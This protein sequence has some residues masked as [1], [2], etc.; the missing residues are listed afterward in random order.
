MNF[1]RE[2]IEARIVIIEDNLEKL[3]QIPQT[4]FAE[5]VEDFRNVEAAKHLLQTAIEAM[6]DICA[7]LVARLRLHAPDNGTRLV[8]ALANANLLPAEHIPR[9]TKMIRFRNLVVHLY[10]EVDDRQ[11]Y[12]IVRNHLDDFRLF[13]ADAW[14]IIQNQQGPKRKA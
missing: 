2:V 3:A 8:Q 4:N 14:R 5:F 10:S 6:V 9:Y 13:I 12:E 7:H 1:D 11:I